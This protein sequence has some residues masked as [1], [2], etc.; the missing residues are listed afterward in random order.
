MASGVTGGV[1]LGTDETGDERGSA[2]GMLSEAVEVAPPSRASGAT[3][4]VVDLVSRCDNS[5]KQNEA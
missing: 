5:C 1:E 3:Q 2:V 4:L